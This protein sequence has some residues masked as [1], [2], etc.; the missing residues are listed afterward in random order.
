MPYSK[1]I[2]E[3]RQ[4][5]ELL[6]TLVQAQSNANTAL[7][8]TLGEL[9]PRVAKTLSESERKDF[10]QAVSPLLQDLTND[11]QAHLAGIRR[12]LDH[13]RTKSRRQIQ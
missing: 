10:V 3:I 5:L 7:A 12:R 2:A 13:L 4:H 1:D 8:S 6:T 9:L 11:T